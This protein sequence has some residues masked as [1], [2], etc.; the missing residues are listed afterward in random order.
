MKSRIPPTAMAAFWDTSAIVPLC[1]FQP[2]TAPARRI[3]RLCAR[4]IVWWVTPVEV[5]SSLARL[6]R[7]NHLDDKESAQAIARLEYLS[8]RWS[9][10]Q[11]SDDVRDQALRLLRIHRLRAADALQLAA[12]L[13]WCSGRP[14]RGHTFVCADNQ[15]L[16]AA[17]LEGFTVV[18]L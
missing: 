13:A 16:Q 7:D 18:K 6:L 8:S 9:E 4:Q 17:D 10:V 15:L 3:A 5:V 1:C 14:K 12:A 11:P 2:A